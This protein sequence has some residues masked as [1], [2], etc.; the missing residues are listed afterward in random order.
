[1][2]ILGLDYFLG[3]DSKA[4]NEAIGATESGFLV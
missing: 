3:K 1:M 2:G 4:L